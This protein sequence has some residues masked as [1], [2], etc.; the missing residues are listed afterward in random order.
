MNRRLAPVWSLDPNGFAGYLFLKNQVLEDLIRNPITTVSHIDM[1]G[2]DSSAVQMSL[3]D[4]DP[5]LEI[6]S[7]EGNDEEGE[8]S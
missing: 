1:K 5:Q 4:M 3:F 2:S 6:G 8:T 7:E